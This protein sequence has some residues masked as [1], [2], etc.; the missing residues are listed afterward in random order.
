[1]SEGGRGQKRR[2]S[3]TCRVWL[4]PDKQARRA[5]RKGAS[6]KRGCAVTVRESGTNSVLL[7]FQ[8]ERAYDSVHGWVSRATGHQIHVC[9]TCNDDGNPGEL[10]D[11]D[12]PVSDNEFVDND[13][14]AAEPPPT[15][16]PEE[17]KG[18]QS[19]SFQQSS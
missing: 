4:P 2:A 18:T 14:S 6:L 5:L 17:T 19:R 13:A 8:K 10:S 11:C 7:V 9:L 12:E 1:M 16:Q 15:A 3:T